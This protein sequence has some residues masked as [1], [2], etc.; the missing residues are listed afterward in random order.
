MHEWH[1]IVFDGVSTTWK[2]MMRGIKLL[3]DFKGYGTVARL[4]CSYFTLFQ[5]HH[6][7]L[8]NFFIKSTSGILFIS[9]SC[10][11]V[12]LLLWLHPLCHLSPSVPFTGQHQIFIASLFFNKCS[13]PISQPPPLTSLLQS[14]Y[15]H[16]LLKR[17]RLGINFP[18]DSPSLSIQT[19]PL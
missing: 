13:A 12:I 2:D 8:G 1:E 11:A 6:Q 10:T 7:C 5:A 16:S 9:A 19:F 4:A 18:D 15:F 14:G 17:D 3:G